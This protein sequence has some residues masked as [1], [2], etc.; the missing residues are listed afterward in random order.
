MKKLLLFLIFIINLFAF[1]PDKNPVNCLPF[2]ENGNINYDYQNIK[3]LPFNEK[4]FLDSHSELVSES[5][6]NNTLLSN[7]Y[8]KAG[9]FTSYNFKNV[10]SAFDWAFIMNNRDAY[11][12]QGNSPT[13][14]D[15]FG[16][17]KVD[18]DADITDSSWNMIYLDDWNNDGIIKFDWVLFQNKDKTN[19]IYKL[20]GVNSNGGFIYDKIEDLKANI[21]GDNVSFE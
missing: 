9:T 3:S 16:W 19:Q 1:S 10:D 8:T 2:D 4:T 15:V 14:K 13:N 7:S 6:L 18:I 21:N 5:L 12:L 11:Q 17:K 20:G